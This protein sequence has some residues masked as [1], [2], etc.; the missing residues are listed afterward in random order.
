MPLDENKIRR[1]AQI[2]ADVYN[3]KRREYNE[4]ERRRRRFEKALQGKGGGLSGLGL[5]IVGAMIGAAILGGGAKNQSSPTAPA[6]QAPAP[7]EQPTIPIPVQQTSYVQAPTPVMP[8]PAQ[9]PAV[10]TARLG[11]TY[12]QAPPQ[13]AP[14]PP[15][16]QEVSNSNPLIVAMTEP[17][18]PPQAVRER[19]EGTAQVLI[20]VGPDGAVIN[21]SIQSS[22]GFPEL[23]RSASEIVYKWHFKPA[24]SNGQPVTSQ[25]VVPVNFALHHG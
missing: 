24:Y 14:I 12:S 4:S 19:H 20:T 16:T 10:P 25:V 3:Q 6:T 1:A 17:R 23:D 2:R 18:Y 7:T 8:A 13:S 15:T 22:S 9:D 5:L 11:V 21:A